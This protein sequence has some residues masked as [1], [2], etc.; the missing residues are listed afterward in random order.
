MPTFDSEMQGWSSNNQPMNRDIAFQPIK[1]EDAPFLYRVYA[2]TRADEMARV[3][4]NDAEKEAFL[5]S[6]FQAQHTFYTEN[7]LDAEFNIILMNGEKI[8]RLYTEKRLDE[9]RIIDIALLPAY[10][11]QGIGG[12]LLQDILAQAQTAVLPVRIH[13]EKNNP[14][15]HLYRRLGFQDIKDKGVYLLMEWTPESDQS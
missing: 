1:P 5:Q 14:A 15:L 12:A 2:S 10:R 11:R 8:G 9:I 4:W 7:F 13:V 3:P 6:Q